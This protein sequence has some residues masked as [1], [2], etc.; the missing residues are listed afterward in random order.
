MKLK[1]NINI[2][3]EMFDYNKHTGVRETKITFKTKDIGD[4]L[5]Q[6]KDTSKL[7]QEFELYKKAL[8]LACDGMGF[9]YCKNCC[10]VHRHVY[11]LD[12][13]TREDSWME[14]YLQKAKEDLGYGD[15]QQEI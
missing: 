1:E 3:Q 9:N 13:D 11:C 8:E 2:L 10:L 5:H 4:L 14:Y 6:L 12:C 7:N 15:F